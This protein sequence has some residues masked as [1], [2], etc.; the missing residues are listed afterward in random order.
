[1]DEP[2][3]PRF[4]FD[5]FVI[6]AG[7]GGLATAKRAASHGAR[8]AIAERDRVGGTCVIRGC[9]PKKLMVY[10]AELGAAI[11]DARG[12]G[13]RVSG[14][15]L[16]WCDLVRR[17]DEAVRRLERAHEEHLE[18]AGVALVRGSARLVG[19]HAVEVGGQVYTARYVLIATG[20]APVLPPIEGIELA[21]T[22]DGFFELAEPP[23][24]VAIVGGGYIA[25]EFASI[26]RGLGTDVTLLIRR[27]MPLRGFDRDLRSELLA[28]LEISGVDV[29]TRVEVT[30]IEK[31][32]TGTAL[33]LRGPDGEDVFQADAVL[34]YAVGR[35]P[36]TEGLGLEQL[37]VAL[38][39]E[40]EVVVDD[41]Q[42]TSVPWVFAVGDVTNRYSLTPVAIQA[43]RLL[44]DRLFGG[45][46]VRMSWEGIPTA[47]FSHPPIAT[48]GLTEEEAVERFGRDGIRVYRS[49]FVPLAYTLAGRKVPTLIKMIVER[50]SDRVI[51]CHMIGRDAPEIIQGMAVAMK[52]GARKADFDATVG[53]HPSS[54]EEFV[55]LTE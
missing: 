42:R 50:A 24:R 14:E 13:W 25:V 51:G 38:G 40:G 9:I 21:I 15:S 16:D 32:P 33:L 36:H 39:S 55:T 46:D 17:R 10:A 18:R 34:V 3:L 12:H 49:R 4:D 48:V 20:S 8:V 26:L 11:D 27:D 31:R 41:D 47:V 53:I 23:S 43:G 7:S 29:R 1:M 37:G 2:G 22:S 44:A 35:A 5:L 6:G 19:P 52:A 30:R 28:A 54:A 45:R